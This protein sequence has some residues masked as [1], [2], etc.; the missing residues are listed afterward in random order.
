MISI[1]GRMLCHYLDTTDIS[2]I[3][4]I[5]RIFLSAQSHPHLPTPLVTLT[6]LKQSLFITSLSLAPLIPYRPSPVLCQNEA[7]F[8]LADLNPSGFDPITVKDLSN[9]SPYK[10]I[11]RVVAC[12]R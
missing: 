11:D 1:V 10:H 7:C 4:I 12:E 3:W 2:I 9:F 8:N 6:F 5:P